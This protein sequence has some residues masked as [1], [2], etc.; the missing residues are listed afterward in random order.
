VLVSGYIFVGGLAGAVQILATAAD[1]AGGEKT[2]GIVRK[3]RYSG[4]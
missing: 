2:A 3:G 1:L 4:F